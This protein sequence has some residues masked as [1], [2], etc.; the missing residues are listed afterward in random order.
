MLAEFTDKIRRRETWFYDRLYWTGKRVL[1]VNMPAFR[2]LY[3]PLRNER[4]FRLST[5]D[6]FRSFIYY[7]PMFRTCCAHCGRSLRLYGG[8]PQITGSPARL[9]IGDEVGM[10]G[11]T[12][13][14]AGKTSANPTLRVGDRTHL[15]YEL[16]INIDAMV[17]IGNDVMV[18]SRVALMGY[19]FHPLDPIKRKNNE[20]PAPSEDDSIVIE[21]LAWIGTR[22]LVL[23][24][25]T[26]GRGSVI[27]AGSVVTK[28][29]PPY[30]LAAGNPAKV[31]RELETE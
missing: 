28:S 17:D 30:S 14:A 21:D 27:A 2:P 6:R 13:I 20:P 31:I 19:D 7:E 24:G 4:S 29:I 15:G 11:R 26:I 12:T 23:K 3:V 22:T 5:W 16:A 9:E 25:V 10:H 8:I 18:A 1:S